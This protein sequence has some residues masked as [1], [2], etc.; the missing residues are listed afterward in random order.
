MKKLIAVILMLTCLI[1]LIACGIKEQAAP[2]TPNA[3]VPSLMYEGKL[4]KTTGKQIPA[5]IDETAIAGHIASVVPLSQFPAKDSEANFGQ[6]GDPY[7]F[8]ADGLVV[9]LDNEWTVFEL[10]AAE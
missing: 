3:T 2:D 10:L 5:E 9:L 7:A 4:Y 6:I 8:T 1:T